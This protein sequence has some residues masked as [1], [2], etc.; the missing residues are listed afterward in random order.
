MA[1]IVVLRP[2]RGRPDLDD[3]LAEMEENRQYAIMWEQAGAA[4]QCTMGK[5]KILG[6]IVN[7]M[8]VDATTTFATMTPEQV[9]N[10]IRNELGEE[11]ARQLRAYQRALEKK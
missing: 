6:M 5:A 11:A 8:Q 9:L 10:Q 4:Q 2:R 1:E 7:R 3:L